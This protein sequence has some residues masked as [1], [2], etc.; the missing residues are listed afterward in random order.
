MDYLLPLLISFVL[1]LI[2]IFLTRPIAIRAGLVDLPNGGRKLHVG[3][4]PLVGG[5]GIYISILTASM[6]FF[7]HSQE[8]NIY[9]VAAAMVLFVGS[10][11]DRYDLSVKVRLIAQVIVASLMIF[12]TEQH[13][14]S[15]GYIIGFTS[16]E[17]GFLGA[18]FT[19]VAI[20]GGINAVNMMDGIDGL[21]GSVSLIAFTSIAF[22]LHRADSEWVLLPIL[23]IPALI[24]YLI[25]NLSSH[26]SLTK[27]FMG[28]AGNMF[29]GLT[30]VWLMVIGTNASE[31]AFKPV[32]ALYLLA[33]PLMDMAAIMYRRLKK[34]LSP[35]KA[36]REHLHHIFERA[37][38][39]REQTLVLIS[40][41]GAL[42]AIIGCWADINDIPEWIMFVGFIAVFFAYNFAL[43][44]IWNVIKF[45]R[46]F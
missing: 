28:D 21:A 27:V 14:T 6:I 30:L 32:T 46:N 41:T 13:F 7:S 3:E 35:F 33:I 31:P 24:A 34:G 17:L 12:G 9:L 42:F 10:L 5:I 39:T 18:L 20:I 37:G 15:L 45:F 26:T 19:I 25:F 43:Q 29:I 1:S 2:T 4:I 8:L 16:I 22:L 23:F 44:N 11:D 36:D 40:A 38:F